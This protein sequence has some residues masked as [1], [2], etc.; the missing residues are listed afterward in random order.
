MSLNDQTDQGVSA[1]PWRLLDLASLF[2]AVNLFLCVLIG[3]LKPIPPHVQ[4][5]REIEKLWQDRG[6]R[7]IE[8][9]D[10]SRPVQVPTDVEWLEG[11][12]R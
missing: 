3:L 11:G 8:E 2:L 10:G 1:G 4:H 5:Q 7:L 9:N 6:E 12:P